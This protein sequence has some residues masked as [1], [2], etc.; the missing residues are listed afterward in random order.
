MSSTNHFDGGLCDLTFENH[1]SHLKAASLW[2]ST[3]ASTI[4][5]ARF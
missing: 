3:S 4:T 2:F 1:V 5:T